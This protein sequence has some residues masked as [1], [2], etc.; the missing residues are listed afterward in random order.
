MW[1]FYLAAAHCAFANDGH[2]NVQIQLAKRRDVLPLSR[3]Y[4][5]EVERT[6]PGGAP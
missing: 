3:D 2:M 5:R 6:L 1:M 4:M